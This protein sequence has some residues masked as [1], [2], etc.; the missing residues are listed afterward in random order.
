MRKLPEELKDKL[1]PASE[2]TPLEP[3][4]IHYFCSKC[5]EVFY[6]S[7]Y[8]KICRIDFE[9]TIKEPCE[10]CKKPGYDYMVQKRRKPL[11]PHK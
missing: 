7:S 6:E 5:A 1:I 8:Y 11:N 10:I 2:L 3:P 4:T 9:Q